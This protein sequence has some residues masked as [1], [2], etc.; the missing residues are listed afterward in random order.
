M[1]H[2]SLAGTYLEAC[3]CGDGCLCCAPGAPTKDSCHVAATWRIEDGTVGGTDLSGLVM[4]GVFDSACV[5]PGGAPGKLYVDERATEQQRHALTHLVTHHSAGRPG[6]V[7]RF[8]AEGEDPIFHPVEMEQQGNQYR[9]RVPGVVDSVLSTA[10]GA[11]A[12]GRGRDMEVGSL[13]CDGPRT[14]AFLSRF[15]WSE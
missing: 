2:I 9:V 1:N 6:G 11:V 4:V 15:R 13:E 5:S 8:L 14:F 3:H 7:G 12:V 10:S